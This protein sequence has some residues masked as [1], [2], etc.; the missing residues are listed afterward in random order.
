MARELDLVEVFPAGRVG[1]G[2]GGKV[3]PRVIGVARAKGADKEQS[4]SESVV[5]QMCVSRER[6]LECRAVEQREEDV[7][8]IKVQRYESYGEVVLGERVVPA[9]RCFLPLSSKHLVRQ[10]SSI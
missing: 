1:G 3:D 6:P 8:V 10:Y 9:W 2:S 4:P 5:A 7:D